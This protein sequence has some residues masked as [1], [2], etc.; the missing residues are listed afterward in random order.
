MWNIIFLVILIGIV[1][2]YKGRVTDTVKRLKA[3]TKISYRP[4][5]RDYNPMINISEQVQYSVIPE[6]GITAELIRTNYNDVMEMMLKDR[7]DTIA[8]NQVIDVFRRNVDV[9]YSHYYLFELFFNQI[10]QSNKEKHP[11][12]E[13]MVAI[14]FGL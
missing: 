2:I 4:K 13:V 7:S 5:Y 3:S 12:H 14:K 8:V 1:V 10:S 9:T 6:M 11:L